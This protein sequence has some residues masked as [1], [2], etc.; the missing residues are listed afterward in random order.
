MPRYSILDLFAG[1]GGLS[2]GFELAGFG[3]DAAVE[4]D[5]WAA[6]TFATNHPGARV[7]VRDI[8]GLKPTELADV[9]IVP[10]VIIGGPPCQGFSHS[11]IGRHDPRDPRNSLFVEFLR[12]VRS[13]GPACCV[14]ENVPGL[15][16][17][18]TARGEQV[19]EVIATELNELGYAVHY[20]ILN[21]VDFGVPQFRERLFVVATRDGLDFCWPE[22]TH[23]G[24]AKADQLALDT[25]AAAHPLV[26]LWDAVSDLPQI[27]AGTATAAGEYVSDPI[28][29]F[30][31]WVR[32]GSGASPANHEPMRH[33]Q[34]VVERFA[35]IGFG[36]S[37]ADVPEALRPFRRSQPGTISSRA[38]SQNS[39]RQRP[40]YPCN[41]IVASSHTNF[42]HPYLHRNFTVRELARIQAFPDNYV[43]QG[44]RA[45]LSKK[46]SIRKGLVDD[47]F[48]DQRAQV[49]NA[50]PPLLAMHLASAIRKAL[51]AVD[52]RVGLAAAA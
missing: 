35:S 26:S 51:G 47:V 9:G 5:R 29:A 18:R 43:F 10:N 19:I 8:E 4:G 33:T 20:K 3:I 14:I 6:H 49:G 12:F 52:L 34:R 1:A 44:K 36:Q 50:V 17:A 40:D 15:L 24:G 2:L 23:H 41:T 21:A 37:E 48:L 31:R 42:I 25:Y 27:V 13:F 46:L 16:S 7:F 28:N 11:N 22:P 30:Q 32:N 38:Y 45:V 39:R